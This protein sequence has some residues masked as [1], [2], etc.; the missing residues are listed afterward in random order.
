MKA[1]LQAHTLMTSDYYVYRNPF[2]DEILADVDRRLGVERAAFKPSRQYR[3]K[4]VKDLRTV[5][6]VPQLVTK[7]KFYHK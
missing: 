2:R 7:N 1:K 4:I 6:Y 3:V 5:P